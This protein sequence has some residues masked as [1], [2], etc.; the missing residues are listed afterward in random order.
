MIYWAGMVF[1]LDSSGVKSERQLTVRAEL[2]AESVAESVALHDPG[3]EQ[4]S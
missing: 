3:M 1:I 2:V 4:P